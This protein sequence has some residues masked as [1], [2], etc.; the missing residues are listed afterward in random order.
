M[1]I[2]T[3]VFVQVKAFGDLT[4]AVSALRRVPG[5]DRE[6]FGLLVSPHLSELVAVL[7]PFCRVETVPLAE[8][9][10]PAFFDPHRRH[11]LD[12]LRSA[13]SLRRAIAGAAAGATLVMPHLAWKNRFVTGRRMAVALPAANNIYAAYEEFIRRASGEL[14]PLPPLPSRRPQ[15]IGISPTSSSVFKNLPRDVIDLLADACVRAGHEPELL[16]LEGDAHE[17]IASIPSRVVPRSFAALRDALT[18]YGAVISADSLPAHLAEFCGTPVFVC[19][20][21]S[22]PY[23]LPPGAFRDR[24]WGTFDASTELASALR[25]FLQRHAMC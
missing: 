3:Y 15:R 8:R 24:S 9:A 7:T 4:I 12:R 21:V 22:N 14:A 17:R 18:T 6:R 23:W 2:P 25:R 20:P 1:T 11:L 5:H 13:V 10:K 16:L 19:S